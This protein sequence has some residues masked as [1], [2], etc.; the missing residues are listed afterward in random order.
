MNTVHGF[1]MKNIKNITN[2]GYILSL[3]ILPQHKQIWHASFLHSSAVQVYTHSI[4]TPE[5][6]VKVL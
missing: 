5:L 1:L 6:S 3:R 4:F 2:P